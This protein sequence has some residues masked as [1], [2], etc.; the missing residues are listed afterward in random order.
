MKKIL[1]AIFIFLPLAASAAAS[2]PTKP[3]FNN[4][5]EVIGSLCNIFQILFTIAILFGIV[6]I[7]LAAFRYMTAGGSAERVGEATRAVRWA[8]VGIVFALLAR[9]MPILI[10]SI[11]G[12]SG[13]LDVCSGKFK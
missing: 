7:L 9:S 13:S 1:A 3:R 12:S 10:A 4:I 5:D 8:V 6:F 11:F 2:E